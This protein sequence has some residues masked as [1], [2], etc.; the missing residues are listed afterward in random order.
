[1]HNDIQIELN[2]LKGKWEVT[3]NMPEDLE[4]LFP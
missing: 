4:P 2:D 3:S 1:M